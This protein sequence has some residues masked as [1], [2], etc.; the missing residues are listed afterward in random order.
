MH[1]LVPEAGWTSSDVP[2]FWDP[3]LGH[4]H[5]GGFPGIG[6][7]VSLRP[8]VRGLEPTQPGC[9]GIGNLVASRNLNEGPRGRSPSR[10]PRT[11]PAV[12]PGTFHLERNTSVA[13]VGPGQTPHCRLTSMSLV[14]K[15]WHGHGLSLQVTSA[16]S[17]SPVD[18][19]ALGW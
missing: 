12:G 10:A 17:S 11:R 19:A 3:T 5:S 1:T 9:T 18:I 14:S 2:V 7:G 15:P 4:P 6:N 13:L 8:A 16:V